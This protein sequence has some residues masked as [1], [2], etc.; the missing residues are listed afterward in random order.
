MI[1]SKSHI[2]EQDPLVRKTAIVPWQLGGLYGPLIL[3]PRENKAGNMAGVLSKDFDTYLDAI[4]K[5]DSEDSSDAL[6]DLLAQVEKKGT[7][8]KEKKR[9]REEKEENP[10][11]KVK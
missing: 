6:E 4:K 5:A 11:K 8:I 10:R 9:E 3:T 1:R 7:L 2:P